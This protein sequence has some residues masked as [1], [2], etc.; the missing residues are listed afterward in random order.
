[1][2]FPREVCE[3]GLTVMGHHFPAGMIIGVQHILCT[4]I[5]SILRSLLSIGRRGGWAMRRMMT[6]RKGRMAWQ[7][8]AFVP[9]SVGPRACLGRNVALLELYVTIAR[10]VFLYDMRLK[11][12]SEDVGVGPHGEYKIRDCFVVGKEGPMLQTRRR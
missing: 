4:T 9:F 11:A 1:M 2:L 3:G 12:G 5:A 10:V 8:E 6:R 7:R